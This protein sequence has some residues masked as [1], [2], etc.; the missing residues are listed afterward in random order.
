MR[1]LTSRVQL[2]RQTHLSPLLDSEAVASHLGVDR[3]TLR[4]FVDGGQ[5]VAVKLPNGHL[6]FK[7]ETLARF[8][9][10]SETTPSQ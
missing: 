10:S 9:A 4:T 6:R 3:R 1:K 7:Q 8:V 5:L 2:R